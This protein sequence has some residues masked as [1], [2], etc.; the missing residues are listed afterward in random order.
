MYW[1]KGSNI[2]EKF[3]VGFPLKPS[4]GSRGEITDLGSLISVVMMLIYP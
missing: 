3:S 2:T 1:D 4:A